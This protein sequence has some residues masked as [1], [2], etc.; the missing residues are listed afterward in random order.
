ME[1]WGSLAA[2]VA[3]AVLDFS[4]QVKP[5]PNWA[6][7]VE[8]KVW[9]SES[10]EENDWVMRVVRAEDIWEGVGDW[11]RGRGQPVVEEGGV[12]SVP[13]WRRSDGCS[14]PWRRG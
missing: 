5:G 7:A 6:S 10:G 2:L 8:M 12:G 1:S 4:S 9:R 13:V 11:E 3:R 14:T